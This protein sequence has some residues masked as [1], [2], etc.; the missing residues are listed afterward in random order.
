M[1]SCSSFMFKVLKRGQRLNWKPGKVLLNS[2]FPVAF[3]P[4]YLLFHEPAHLHRGDPGIRGTAGLQN[5]LQ[6]P[7]NHHL[8][9][10]PRHSAPEH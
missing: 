10:Q 9:V 7:P 1:C 6:P 3:G 4:R 8:G 2:D 5:H